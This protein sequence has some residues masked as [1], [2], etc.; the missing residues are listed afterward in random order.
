MQAVVQTSNC[1]F[2]MLKEAYGACRDNIN[3]LVLNPVDKDGRPITA[4][5]KLILASAHNNKMVHAPT[6]L[7]SNTSINLESSV[8]CRLAEMP[9]CP[10][11]C[12]T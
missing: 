9:E 11:P 5:Q 8:M 12:L 10:N 6:V 2:E 1:N 3:V 7:P 4:V